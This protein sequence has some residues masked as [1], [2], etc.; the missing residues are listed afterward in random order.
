MK[1][2]VSRNVAQKLAVVYHAYMKAVDTNDDLGISVWGRILYDIQAQT[3][4][5]LTDNERLLSMVRNQEDRL[6]KQKEDGLEMGHRIS[7]TSER[8][9]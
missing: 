6:M 9:Q 5:E 4:I 2:V 1:S 7:G 3:E 8:A